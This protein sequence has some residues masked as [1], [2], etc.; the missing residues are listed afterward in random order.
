[1]SKARILLVEDDRALV[2]LLTF[3]LERADFEVAS[4]ADGEESRGS[5]GSRCA[6]GCAGSTRPRTCRSSC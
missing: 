4:T 2:E 3:H 6:G 5:P 1:M